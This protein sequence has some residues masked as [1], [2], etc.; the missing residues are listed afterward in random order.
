MGNIMRHI[1]I[2]RKQYEKL[3]EVFE[4]Y[5]LDRVI[6]KEEYTSGIGPNVTLEFDP[7]NTVKL[8]IT[9]IESW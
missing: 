8:D 3:K 5:D 1:V 4:M 6:W 9:D 2:T 7:R